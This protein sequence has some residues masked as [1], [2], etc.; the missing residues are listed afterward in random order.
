M[1]ANL[2]PRKIFKQQAHLSRFISKSLKIYIEEK[3]FRRFL[4]INFNLI[5]FSG[6]VLFFNTRLLKADFLFTDQKIGNTNKNINKEKIKDILQK[7]EELILE[8]KK[9]EIKQLNRQDDAGLKQEISQGKV[10]LP[11]SIETMFNKRFNTNLSQFGYNFFSKRIDGKL[12]P[13]DRNYRLGPGDSLSVYFWGDPVD[14]LG[15]QNFYS[16]S[17]DRNGKVFLPTLGVFYVWQLTVKELKKL[18]RR[19]LE[20]KF[21]RFEVEITLGELRSFPVYV[22]GHVNNPGIVKASSMDS[23]IEIISES[24]GVAKHGS[25]RDIKVIRIVNNQ[26]KV[27]PVD[28]YDLFIKGNPIDIR[29]QSG[30]TIFVNTIHKAIAITGAVK[31][32]AIYEFLGNEKTE[33]SSLLKISG[34]ILPFAYSLSIKHFFIKNNKVTISEGNLN[35]KNFLNKIIKS[36]NMVQ[37]DGL[38]DLVKNKIVVKGIIGY[39]GYFTHKKGLKLSQLIKKVGLLPETNMEFAEI[40]REKTDK[41]ITFSPNDVM[42]RQKDFSI[43]ERDLIFFYPK[44][45]YDYIIISGMIKNPKIIPYHP[46]ITML[47]I[48]K[49]LNFKKPVR[50]LKA[51]LFHDDQNNDQNNDQKIEEVQRVIYLDDLLN[52]AIPE[53]NVTLSPGMKILIERLKPSERQRS[54]TILGEVQKPGKYNLK[55]DM[56]LS[57]IIS[58]AG[59]YSPRA[60]PQG[61]IYIRNSFKQIQENQ[62]KNYLLSIEE[63]LADHSAQIARSGVSSEEKDALQFVLSGYQ[64]SLDVIKKKSQMAMG[65]VSLEIPENLKELK[66]HIDNIRLEDEDYIFIPSKPNY[67][68]IL[69]SV[70]NQISLPFYSG[71]TVK[72]YLSQVGGLSDVANNENMYIIQSNGK[73]ISKAQYKSN[74]DIFFRVDWQKKKIS[75][76]RDFESLHLREGDAIIVPKKIEV[77]IPWRTIIRDVTQIIFQAITTAVLAARL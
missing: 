41:V 23:I 42:T 71:K 32:P 72:Y 21:R 7:K 46:G 2:R 75:F 64:K 35:D 56:R 3:M 13:T 77:S 33:L 8:Q 52:K 63:Y 38:A 44:R 30:D 70:Y 15:L 68:L 4:F 74:I 31:R 59:G 27:I 34:G 17:V 1:G 73:I 10:F 11:S 22:C 45:I 24:G 54:V 60:F 16:I 53:S 55:S 43:E 50:L 29:M 57:D 66:N 67:I 25:L 36:G 12:M 48:V 47:D 19:A 49:D 40:I 28:L 14:I 9:K 69:G 65:R 20:K 62:L 76:A 37:V 61:I 39:P 18:V 6:M 5:I 51:F 26:K 58:T